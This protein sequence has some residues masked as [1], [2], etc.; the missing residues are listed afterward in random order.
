MNEHRARTT[1]THS[2]HDKLQ[3]R[4]KTNKSR[5][6]GHDIAVCRYLQ[7]DG[8]DLKLVCVHGMPSKRVQP[9]MLFI[10]DMPFL[11]RTH[12]RTHMHT[13]LLIFC[14]W[15]TFFR[16]L[17]FYFL[18]LFHRLSFI[19]ARISHR[20]QSKRTTCVC[21]LRQ[22]EMKKNSEE[23][24][25]FFLSTPSISFSR[26]DQY[27][28]YDFWQKNSAGIIVRKH[29]EYGWKAKKKSFV[30]CRIYTFLLLFSGGNTFWFT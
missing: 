9:P 2:V 24:V 25:L 1:H 19:F 17:Q 28:Y 5:I 7:D 22:P 21:A 15:F 27:I 11:Y 20:I 14:R 26:A 16:F 10:C 29:E 13:L 12:K 4:P 8:L 23:K 18:I 3:E 6:M 30:V